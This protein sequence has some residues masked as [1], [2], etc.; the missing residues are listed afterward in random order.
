[1]FVYGR[2]VCGLSYWL[3]VCLPTA[4]L[5]LIA[6]GATSFVL[7][8]NKQKFKSPPLCFVVAQSHRCKA[9]QHHRLLS[10]CPALLP[11]RAA[12]HQNLRGPCL[13][14][15]HHVLPCFRPE[16][17]RRRKRKAFALLNERG[18]FSAPGRVLPMG[19]KG[20]R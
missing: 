12:L 5:P 4:F 15:G 18:A 13:R 1:M 16:A 14:T 20:L 2:L 9:G 11:L 3:A 7:K 6:A 19:R 8:Q 10:F 17:E